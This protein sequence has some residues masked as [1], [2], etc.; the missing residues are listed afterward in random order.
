MPVAQDPFSYIAATQV[1][2]AC[3]CRCCSP[4]ENLP[5]LTPIPISKKAALV[6]WSHN[7][8]NLRLF[9]FCPPWRREDETQTTQNSARAMLSLPGALWGPC[10]SLYPCAEGAE[11]SAVAYAPTCSGSGSPADKPLVLDPSGTLLL[12]KEGILQKSYK[13][14]LFHC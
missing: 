10:C 11:S 1:H 3:E 13:N 6:L 8:C 2:G 9:L 12:V 14:F 5:N 4:S 7:T